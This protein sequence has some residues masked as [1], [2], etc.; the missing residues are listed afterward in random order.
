MSSKKTPQSVGEIL[1]PGWFAA[2]VIC[3]GWALPTRF[4]AIS[5]TEIKVLVS[6]GFIVES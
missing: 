1:W 2:I 4:A 6:I 5:A 3:A